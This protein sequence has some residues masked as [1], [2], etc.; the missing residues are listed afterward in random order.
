MSTLYQYLIW[1]TTV[2]I[3]IIQKISKNHKPNPLSSNTAEFALHF[4]RKLYS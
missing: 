1:S 4:I 2:F 3:K